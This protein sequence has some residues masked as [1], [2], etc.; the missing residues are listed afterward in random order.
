MQCTASETSLG[1]ARLPGSVRVES[2]LVASSVRRPGRGRSALLTLGVAAGI[3]ALL[4]LLLGLA[5]SGSR[6]ELAEGARVAG[7]D[8]GG[9]AQSEA[10]A[11]LS[12]RFSGRAGDP[13]VFTAGD[14][15]FSFA[16][17][18]LGVEPDW[19]AAVAAAAR[20]GDGFGP[21]RGFR[22]LR[23][24][25]FGAEVLPR[26]AVSDAAL[27]FALDRVAREVDRA[28]VSAAL[29]RRGLRVEAV[30]ESSGARLDRDEAAEIIVRT[31]GSLDRR[32]ASPLPVA[33]AA[34]PVTARML[35]PAARRARIALSGPVTLRRAGRTWRV[36][37]ARIAQLLVLPRDGGRKLA[38]AGPAATAYFAALDRRVA[39]PALDATF[40]VS[41][42]VVRVVPSRE[43]TT[44]NVPRSASALLRAAT[45]RTN[46]VA[47]LTIARATPERTTAEAQAMGI[48]RRLST[49]KTFN[50]GTSDRIT[51]LRLGVTMLD[52]TLVPPGGTFS[53]NQAIGERTVERGFRS[54]PVII[55]TEYA[56]EV[57]GGTS[58]VATT[59]F[60]A[61]WEAGLRIT[62]RNPHSL[63]I[64]RYQLGRD[65]TVYWPSLDLAF[66]NDTERWVLVKGFPEWDGIRVS[67]YGGESRRVESSPG[68]RE[69]TGSP[70]VK[71]VKDPTLAKGKTVVDSPGTAPSR[72]SVTR[73]I[74]AA[75]GT[76]IR[77]ETW[78]TSYKGET[79]VVRVGT[80]VKKP[81][82][83]PTA[84]PEQDDAPPAGGDASP[85]PTRP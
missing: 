36:S 19:R 71:R 44:M 73:T 2:P 62:E 11:L 48:D 30:P 57:G 7:V 80:K 23:T 85:P 8:V 74:Y 16:A 18:Q 15:S 40:A 55:G 20:A 83:A 76:L 79:R 5:F 46:R 69:V 53:L 67:I 4:V 6:R 41:G 21:I 64:S 3:A 13:V 10:V 32:T 70:P 26:I 51:N 54:A 68:T 75:D 31:L 33:L 78:N 59:V 12:A 38:V 47:G 63:Y 58:Q 24:R 37:R 61:A 65:A 28:P 50:S 34:P 39:R 72:T 22:R 35:A 45:S 84:P 42:D 82:K 17:S 60:N 27:E 1:A 66:V 43:G 29:V 49:Y 52:G 25:F 81:G 56:E 14:E 9:M 77:T